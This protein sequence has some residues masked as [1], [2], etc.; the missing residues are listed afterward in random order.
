MARSAH[1]RATVVP[2][3]RPVLRDVPGRA[4]GRRVAAP[5][6]RARRARFAFNLPVPLLAFIVCLAVLAVGRV[7]LS[8]AVVQKNLQTDS[9]VRQYRQL[10]VQNA[11]LKEQAA[12]MSSSLAL[13]GIAI[14]RYHLVVPSRVEYVTVSSAAARK[15]GV[16]KP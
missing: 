2:A 4:E 11:Q 9:V 1:A 12:S 14:K 16:A 10:T 5:T 15:A 8:F 13:R 3:S 6:K 7:T